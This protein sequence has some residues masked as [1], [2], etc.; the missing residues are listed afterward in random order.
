MDF[1]NEILVK[2]Y[3]KSSGLDEGRTRSRTKTE[4]VLA[5]MQA[6][7]NQGVVN[8]EEMNDLQFNDF[9]RI[10]NGVFESGWKHFGYKLPQVAMMLGQKPNTVRVKATN[11]HLGRSIGRG[12]EFTAAEV[13]ALRY[14][15]SDEDR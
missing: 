14:I 13:D 12:L 3:C 2:K 7:D 5:A 9:T 1:I 10:L 8:W 15:L 6:L 11:Y 4:A